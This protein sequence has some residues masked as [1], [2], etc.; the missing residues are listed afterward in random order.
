MVK[1]SVSFSSQEK[2]Q[3]TPGTKTPWSSGQALKALPRDPVR[4]PAA[5]GAEGSPVGGVQLCSSNTPP[6]VTLQREKEASQKSFF[7]P[8]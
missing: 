5:L 7:E 3:L 2:S 4:V 6:L 1:N 8:V